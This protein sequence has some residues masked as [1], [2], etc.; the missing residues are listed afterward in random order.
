VFFFNPFVL[1]KAKAS[2][3]PQATL[4][5]KIFFKFLSLTIAGATLT[6]TILLLLQVGFTENP[7]EIIDKGLR[8]EQIWHNLPHLEVG[9]LSFV[10]TLM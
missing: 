8:P 7:Y 5:Y 9:L 6:A 4:S 3:L 10:F 2:I 1:L